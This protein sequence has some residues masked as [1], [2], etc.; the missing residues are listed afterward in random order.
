MARMMRPGRTTPRTGT[1]F[2][3]CLAL[4]LSLAL[5][6]GVGPVA[7][8]APSA[9][10]DRN[11]SDGGGAAK[12]Q[13]APAVIGSQRIGTSLRG[14]PIRAF[15]LGDPGAPA[16]VVLGSMHGNEKAGMQVVDAL[17]DGP[18]V[19]GVDLWVV[20]TMNPDG[21]A[22]DT[23]GNARGVDLNR[24]FRRGWAP[25]TGAYY[26][27][28]GPMSEPETRAM[29]L[30]LR[31]VDPTY[32]V[33]F[34]QPLHGVGRAGERRPFQRRLAQGLGL[35]IKAFNCS[36]VCHGTMTSWF[37]ATHRGT[38]ITVE[39]GA[40]PARTYLRGRATRGTLHAVLG[41]WQ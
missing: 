30:F 23:R 3:L 27:G 19:T 40:R 26:S 32:V 22:R 15:H 10:A 14:R 9:A 41:S 17:R 6:L 8:V 20:P 36:G 35:R 2:V 34:H 11:R 16:A 39:F 5:S 33:S 28:T 18:P 7:V 38:A 1:G 4:A 24:N 31:R 37:N 21:V 12:D 29:A 25:L 13:R